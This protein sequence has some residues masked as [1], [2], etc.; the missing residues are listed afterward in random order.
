MP[1][2]VE[3]AWALL[4]PK[5]RSP[6]SKVKHIAVASVYYSSTQTRKSDFLDHITESYNLLCAKY[7]SDLKFLI[8][9]D[10]NRLNIKP[11]LNLS[12]DLHQVVKVI[13]RTNPD[14]TLDVI[15]TNISALYQPPTT[16][17]PLGQ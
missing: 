13:T 7:G 3:V 14:A 5:Y 8:L 11:I 2:D 4:T 12:P 1:I 15:I 9:G 17:P 16:L 10:I 6:Q